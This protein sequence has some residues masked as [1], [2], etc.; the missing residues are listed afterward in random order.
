MTFSVLEWYDL[1]KTSA[2]L[3]ATFYLE[4]GIHT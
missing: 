4:R 3:H 1:R 2:L